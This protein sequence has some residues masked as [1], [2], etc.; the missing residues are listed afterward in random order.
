M[1]RLLFLLLLLIGAGARAQPTVP[2]PLTY[3]VGA[4]V[5]DV[6]EGRFRRDVSILVRGERIEALLP[7]GTPLPAGASEVDVSG[8][9]AI[10]GLIDVHQHIANGQSRRASEGLLRRE[11][12]GGVTAIRD[13]VGDARI[14]ADLS[15]SALVG[16]IPA[17]D[18]IYSGLVAGPDFF[19]DGRMD[20]VSRGVK[21]G[22]VPWLR[23]ITPETDVALAIAEMRGAGASGVKIYTD[24]SEP[25]VRKI[26]AEAH[27]QKM[28]VW[29]HG[30]I[31][32][33]SPL[34]TVEA[35]VDTVSHIC[36]LAY[37]ASNPMPSRY[38]DRPPVDEAA[39]A[40]P[41]IHPALRRI[42]E[43]M[44]ARGTILDTTIHVYH[45]IERLRRLIPDRPPPTYCSSGL[46]EKLT[47]QAW[48]AGVTL[49]AGTDGSVR[50]ASLYPALFEEMDLLRD[51]AKIPPL[52][53]IR[54]ATVNAARALGREGEMGTIEPARL[55]N[56]AFLSA[57]P[58]SPG[59]SFRSVVLTVKR[60]KPYWRRDYVPVTTA[61]VGPEY[62][63]EEKDPQQP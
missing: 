25:L 47:G 10:P 60:G 36:L 24:L 16:D 18:I 46:A 34:Q 55:A 37:Q 59:A 11:L 7:A 14:L 62:G 8:L 9:Y 32:P 40:G 30:A 53:V 27:R 61:E 17:P 1:P 6:R 12:F 3:Y 63:I 29:A 15:R 58:L 38:H 44:K 35:G 43:A 42:F 21:A 51:R 26:A 31:F 54:A 50:N 19:S 5:L 23:A 45:E 57:D 41:E 39:L 48:Q 49:A 4:S 22:E 56:L 2:P 13:M 33:L 20:A 28:R 52:D